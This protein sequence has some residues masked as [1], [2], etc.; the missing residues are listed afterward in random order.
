MA[1]MVLEFPNL[2]PHLQTPNPMAYVVP[3]MKLIPQSMQMACWYASAQMLIRWRRERTGQCEAGISDPSE[4]AT[5]RIWK[6]SD[7]GISD[8]QI[9]VLANRLG[10]QLV[11]PMSPTTEALES[12]LRTYGPLWTNG[13]THIT[14]IAG[15][16]GLNVKVYDPW[17]VNTGKVEW[18]NLSTWYTGNSASSRDT[19]TVSGVF[20]HCPR[21]PTFVR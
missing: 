12:W 9:Q 15:I 2:K 4:D 17:P 3:G 6:A 18:R 8:A 20:M 10:L 11:P 14:V 5:L 1:A 21:L 13:S 19:K 16:Q 7:R